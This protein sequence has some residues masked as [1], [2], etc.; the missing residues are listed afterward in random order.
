M[1]SKVELDN[2]AKQADYDA[3]MKIANEQ[4][5]KDMK[6][7]QKEDDVAAVKYSREM[8]E[9]LLEIKVDVKYSQ[10]PGVKH[11]S[12]DNAFADKNFMR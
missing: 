4:Y 5:D 6:A 12:W 11:N 9:R 3:K 7:W 2:A 1:S 8:V 10:Y